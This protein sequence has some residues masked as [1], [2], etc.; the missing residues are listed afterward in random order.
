[1]DI[2][3]HPSGQKEREL[4]IEAMDKTAPA[5]RRAYLDAACGD[6]SALRCR[7]ELL[8]KRFAQLD[9]FLEK[10]VVSISA[11]NRDAL[12]G[13]GEPGNATERASPTEQAGDRIGRYKL[14]DKIGEGGCGV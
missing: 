10:P 3:K 6:D 5:E 7:I 12:S 11:A 1:M 14:L 13:A 9:T 8:L 4:F 2:S